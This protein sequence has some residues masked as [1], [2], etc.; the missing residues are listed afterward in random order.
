MTLIWPGYSSSS[1]ICLAMSRASTTAS[2]SRDL[3]RLDHDADLAAGLHGVG[4]LDALV[5]VG[6]RLELLEPLDVALER[7]AAG[8]GASGR[9][10]VGGLHEDGLDGLR[11]DVAVVRLDGVDDRLG[12]VHPAGE[13]GA[14]DGVR[15]LDLVVDGLA[16]VVQQAGALGELHVDAELGG[17]D[18][19]E[20]ATSSECLS[21]FWP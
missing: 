13:V 4:L 11:L 2:A 7:L 10:G 14:D 6:D 1:S 20:V 5:R 17:H 21:T 15:A 19:G 12:L 18:A 3:L 16:E 9:D 8:T